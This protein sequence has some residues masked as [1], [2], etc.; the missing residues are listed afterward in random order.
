MPGAV[1]LA[2]SRTPIAVQEA[3]PIESDGI[4]SCSAMTVYVHDHAIERERHLVLGFG[5]LVIA[6]KRVR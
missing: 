3:H 2:A 4:E 1:A 6:A 5:T